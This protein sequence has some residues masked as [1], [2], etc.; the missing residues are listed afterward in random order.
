MNKE[1]IKLLVR[2]RKKW[3]YTYGRK[4]GTLGFAYLI[5]W[6]PMVIGAVTLVTHHIINFNGWT[7]FGWTIV[8]CALLLRWLLRRVKEEA[9]DN[10]VETLV[11]AEARGIDEED[12]S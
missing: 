9:V 2:N 3:W 5:L 12:K 10:T 7:A 1:E 11:E 6:L 4:Y 8:I